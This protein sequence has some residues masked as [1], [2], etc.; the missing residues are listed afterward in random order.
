MQYL[1]DWLSRKQDPKRNYFLDRANATHALIKA[2][3]RT[4]AGVFQ[5]LLRDSPA[6]VK[7]RVLQLIAD[8]DL[9]ALLP[10]ILPSLTG[11]DPNISV[12]ASQTAVS[13]A[14][15]AYR[16]RLRKIRQE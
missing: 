9:H 2:G 14:H 13:M 15:N 7:L 6:V 12:T 1:R 8:L 4:N 11:Q 5:E 3:D 10:M 16:D